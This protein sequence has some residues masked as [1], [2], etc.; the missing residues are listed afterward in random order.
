MSQT[1]FETH[2]ADLDRLRELEPERILPA[3]GDP[4]VIAAGGYPTDLIRATQQYIRV[5]QRIA[6]EPGCAT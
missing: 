5:L 4:D 1:N 2:L 3:H 6:A